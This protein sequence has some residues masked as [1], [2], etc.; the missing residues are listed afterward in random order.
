M[1]LIMMFDRNKSKLDAKAY[2]VSSIEDTLT[3]HLREYDIAKFRYNK[4]ISKYASE[5]LKFNNYEKLI[6]IL[7]RENIYIEIVEL[8]YNTVTVSIFFDNYINEFIYYINKEPYLALQTAIS[9]NKIFKLGNRLETLNLVSKSKFVTDKALIYSNI[10]CNHININSDIINFT[11]CSNELYTVN[12]EPD[13]TESY[14]SIYDKTYNTT[15]EIILSNSSI[16][17]YRDTVKEIQ[18]STTSQLS[19]LLDRAP[20]GTKDKVNKLLQA[21]NVILI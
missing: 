14:I 10:L 11:T 21:H 12:I 18:V 5:N 8:P 15:L 20:I 2:S 4:N 13:V 3:L 17:V 1:Y 16:T 9:E 7:R 19:L 6:K